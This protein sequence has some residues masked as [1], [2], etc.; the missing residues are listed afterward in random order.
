MTLESLS[1]Q[2]GENMGFGVDFLLFQVDQFF[3]QIASPSGHNRIEYVMVREN[4][5]GRGLG[6]QFLSVALRMLWEKARPLS[7]SLSAHETNHP[8][9]RVYERLGFREVLGL[10]TFSR[11]IA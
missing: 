8:A 5:R 10:E 3:E 4:L 1:G 2:T 7:L 11:S 6:T 9:R